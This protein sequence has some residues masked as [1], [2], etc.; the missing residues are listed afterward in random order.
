VSQNDT[1]LARLGFELASPSDPGRRGSHLS[2]R[3]PHAWPIDL[4]LIDRAKVIPD[5]RAPDTLR[6][7]VSALY[8][9]FV[10][11]H[12]AVQRIA[13]V[14]TGGVYQDYSNAKATVT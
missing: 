12:T 5:F 3:H 10:Q 13:Q 9:T 4:A 14:V 7:G 6:L 2:L 8:T 11:I 1:H